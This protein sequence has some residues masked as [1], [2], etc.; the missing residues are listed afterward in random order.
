MTGIL[1][2]YGTLKKGFDNHHYLNGADYLGTG[3]VQGY[4]LLDLGEYPGCFPGDRILPVEIYRISAEMLSEIDRLEEVPDLY[5]R[6]RVTAEG[7]EEGWIYI[8]NGDPDSLKSS[9]SLCPDNIWI[10]KDNG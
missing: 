1:F 3:T 9:Y 7:G 6:K 10:K 5:H 8:L 2:V 4:Q